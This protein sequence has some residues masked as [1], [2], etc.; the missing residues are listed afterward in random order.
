[1]TNFKKYAAMVLAVCLVI[2]LACMSACGD[3]NNGD[4]TTP[5]GQDAV[6]T[7]TPQTTTPKQ[8][9]PKQTTTEGPTETVTFPSDEDNDPFQEDVFA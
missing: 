9:T 7:T 1:M 3:K 6:T 8:T 2:V 5:A 4:E